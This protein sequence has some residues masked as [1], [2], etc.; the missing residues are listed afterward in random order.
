MLPTQRRQAILAELRDTAAVSA[1]ALARQ[2]GVSVETIRRDL[3]TLGPRLLERVYGGATPIRSTEGSFTA[4][5]RHHVEGQTGDRARWRPR[6]GSQD[7]TII[8]DI[9]TTALEVARAL[10]SR[11]PRPGADQF[12]PGR[13]GAVQPG[14]VSTCCW[15]A[16]RCGP[17]TPPALERTRRP[18]SSEFYADKAFLGSGGVPRRRP[19]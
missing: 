2:Y 9:G 1:E 16:A 6:W 14:T 4:R 17:A 12:R 7:D 10:P 15:P 3:R 19:A 8:I 5:H 11:L 18:S 13:D